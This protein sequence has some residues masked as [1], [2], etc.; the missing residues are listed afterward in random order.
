MQHRVFT[1]RQYMHSIQNGQWHWHVSALVLVIS[2]ESAKTTCMHSSSFTDTLSTPNLSNLAAPTFCN[3]TH[4]CTFPNTTIKLCGRLQLDLS[5][6]LHVCTCRLLMLLKLSILLHF[7]CSTQASSWLLVT[8]EKL[9]LQTYRHT[10]RQTNNY[11]MPS[12]HV[13]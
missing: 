7:A 10:Y 4:E 8:F 9:E 6:H 11:H 12:V 3:N 5:L 13:H 1:C 2:T